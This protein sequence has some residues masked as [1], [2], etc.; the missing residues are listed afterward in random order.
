M[1]LTQCVREGLPFPERMANAP[2]LQ[3]GLILYYN[4]W[5]ELDSCRTA[6]FGP[7]PIP[8][9]AIEGY[10][11]DL[12]LTREQ[13]EDMHFMVRALDAAYLEHWQR[14]HGGSGNG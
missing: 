6:G 1:V 14:K 2:E 7:G 5:A 4:A 10:C 8:W 9:I 3:P 12:E 13:R 11:R